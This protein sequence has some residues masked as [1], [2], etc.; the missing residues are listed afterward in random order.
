VSECV[1]E[2]VRDRER[3]CHCVNSYAVAEY[4]M[5]LMIPAWSASAFYITA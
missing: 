4:A 5:L 3:D 2:C 1:S